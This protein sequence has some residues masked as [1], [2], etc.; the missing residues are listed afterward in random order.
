MYDCRFLWLRFISTTFVDMFQNFD[1]E[2]NSIHTFG[3]RAFLPFGLVCILCDIRHI[4]NGLSLTV[5]KS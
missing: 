3:P 1:V 4:L 2:A 5:Q